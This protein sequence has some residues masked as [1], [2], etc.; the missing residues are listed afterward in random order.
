MVLTEETRIQQSSK[1]CCERIHVTVFIDANNASGETED[2][3]TNNVS[4]TFLNRIYPLTLNLVLL[5]LG[6]KLAFSRAELCLESNS[7]KA[8]SGKAG[9]FTHG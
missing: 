2:Q 6:F 7:A 3:Q 4:T 1:F 8:D 5:R 9:C